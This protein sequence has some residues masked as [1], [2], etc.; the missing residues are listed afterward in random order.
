VQVSDLDRDT[1]RRLAEL[2]PDG[3]RVLSLYLNL[4]PSEFGT[5]AA[6]ATEVH[7]LTD[8]AARRAEAIEDLTHDQKKALR[9]DIQRVRSFLEGSDFSPG[10]ARGVAVFASAPADLFE[11][12]R[13]PRA[14]DSQVFIDD[15]PLVEPMAD[16]LNEGRWAVLLVSRRTG[17]LF[18]GSSERL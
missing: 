1:L 10:G 16:L 6:R 17:R 13:L 2:R 9:D 15:S 11:T 18:V 14:V 5:P 7:S 3:A 8:D 12:V 4:D